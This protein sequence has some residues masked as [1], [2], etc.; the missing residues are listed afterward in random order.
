MVRCDAR[1][2]QCKRWGW[3][4]LKKMV[5]GWSRFSGRHILPVPLWDP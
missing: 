4:R 1:A 2:R 5:G 3:Q